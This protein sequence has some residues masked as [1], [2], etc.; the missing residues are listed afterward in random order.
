MEL[1]VSPGDKA[2]DE[3]RTYVEDLNLII[4]MYVFVHRNYKCMLL[5][6]AGEMILKDM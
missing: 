3:V 1:A 6:L 4:M 2:D 5:I